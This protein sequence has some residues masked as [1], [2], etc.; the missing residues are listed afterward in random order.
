MMEWWWLI[1]VSAIL[2]FVGW[3]EPISVYV[4]FRFTLPNLH[5]VC[6]IVQCETQQWPILEPSPNDGIVECWPPARRAYASE[7][8]LGM[9]SGKRPILQK[10]LE[11]HFVWSTPN[12]CFLFLPHKILHQNKKNNAII[13]ALSFVFLIPS[14]HNSSIPLFQLWAKRTK[15]VRWKRWFHFFRPDP[16]VC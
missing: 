2:H 12:I 9:E 1:P 14:F 16:K 13:C 6:S 3:V 10:M 4:G 8:I 11:L 5:F 7:R 15:F